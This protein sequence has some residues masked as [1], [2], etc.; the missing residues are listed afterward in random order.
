MEKFTDLTA[1]AC[2][3]DIAN[4]EALAGTPG[5]VVDALNGLLL[6]NTMDAHNPIDPQ[7]RNSLI[8]AMNA[9]NDANQTTR[10][11]KRARVA[12][13]LVATSSQYDIQR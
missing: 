3:I 13:Y 11:Q 5:A 10:N 12:V 8:S 7:M 1:P 9:I 6:H 2:P 4:L